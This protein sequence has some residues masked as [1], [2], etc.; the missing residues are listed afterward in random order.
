MREI[1]CSECAEWIFAHGCELSKLICRMFWSQ[2]T[3][4]WNAHIADNEKRH[5][6]F[7]TRIVWFLTSLEKFMQKL[8]WSF[9]LRR[10][11]VGTQ[12]KEWR[13]IE[14][15]NQA[16]GC[17]FFGYFISVMILPALLSNATFHAI[18][19]R[20]KRRQT[21]NLDSVSFQS[22]S[23]IIAEFKWNRIILFYFLSIIITRSRFDTINLWFINCCCRCCGSPFL[24]GNF[25]T[26]NTRVHSYIYARKSNV[27]IILRP[28][29]NISCVCGITAFVYSTHFTS[30]P[31]GD[32][33]NHFPHRTAWNGWDGI[34]S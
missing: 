7:N 30:I 6:I 27:K 29:I 15:E 1:D 19:K 13:K 22:H 31:Y 12:R 17:P 24:L 16:K 33:K 3:F 21:W 23:T 2:H 9:S 18:E 20:P 25:E 14:W 8:R 10:A 11:F 28:F 26:Y 34:I 4:E 5:V 32:S